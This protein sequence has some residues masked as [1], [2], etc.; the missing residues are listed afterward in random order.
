MKV[1]MDG[2]FDLVYRPETYRRVNDFF[3]ARGDWASLLRSPAPQAVLVPMTEPVEVKM[4]AQ[5]G[6]REAYHDANDAIFLPQL[7]GAGG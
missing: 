4:K 6:W 3:G 5:P 1:S 7:A 2:R